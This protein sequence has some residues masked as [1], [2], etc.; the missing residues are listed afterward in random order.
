[1][2]RTPLLAG[3]ALTVSAGVAQAGMDLQLNDGA[4][5]PM[6]RTNIVAVGVVPHGNG[7]NIFPVVLAPGSNCTPDITTLEPNK[8]YIS[9]INQ[10]TGNQEGAIEL[11]LSPSNVTV[12]PFQDDPLV[13]QSVI[14]KP[15]K[16]IA[17]LPQ[18]FSEC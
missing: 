4:N 10:T 16:P 13:Y 3:L 6:T 9:I 11:R 12:V 7:E 1:M 2:A 18:D 15:F 5:I 8:S 17:R 14:I